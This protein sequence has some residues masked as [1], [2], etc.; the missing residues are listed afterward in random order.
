MT[1]HNQLST[2]FNSKEFDSPDLMFSGNYISLKLIKILEL[3]RV[4]I[5]QP[6]TINSGY[7]T[8]KHN[9][10][11]GGTKNSSHL[12]GFAADIRITTDKQR[13]LF[14]AAAVKFGINRIG[15]RKDFI[16]IDIDSNKNSFRTW[17]Y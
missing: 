12:R 4:E 6:I 14:L 11:V 10:F 8:I 2:N 17:L 5:K 3:I 16:H 1:K 15:I 7:R 13:F 9:K